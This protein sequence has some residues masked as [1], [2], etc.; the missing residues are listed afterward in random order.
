M[1]AALLL[2]AL[3]LVGCTSSPRIDR[4][5]YTETHYELPWMP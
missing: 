4:G 3:M 1:K 2:F 5:I